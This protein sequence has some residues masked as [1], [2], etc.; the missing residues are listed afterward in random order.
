MP[1][2]QSKQFGVGA[3]VPVRQTVLNGAVDSSGF[4]SALSIGAGLSVTL[5]GTGI[6]FLLSFAA[7]FDAN[8]PVDY[9]GRFTANQTFSGLTA[10]TTCFLYV[11][12][13]STTGAL[14]IGF[15]TLAPTYQPAAP[16]SPATGQHWFDLSSFTMKR[17]SGSAWVVFQ[18]VFVGACNTGASTVTAVF[19]YAY[20]GIY[21]SLWIAVIAN[22]TYTF[23]HQLGMFLSQAAANIQVFT[24]IAG[25]DSDS[26]IATPF[27]AIGSTNYGY[28][29]WYVGGGRV[30]LAIATKDLVARDTSNTFVST[31]YY[32]VCVN[33]G[34]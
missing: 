18:R 7:G 17:W 33:R 34:W 32:K 12:R 15:T 16:S 26:I 5:T 9:L 29:A 31:G 8:G 1:G 21:Q 2:V 14:T 10:N 19:T 6:P 3:I 20:G 4:P 22:T 11:D 13:D 24:S 25:N 23:N 30:S 27:V 28:N